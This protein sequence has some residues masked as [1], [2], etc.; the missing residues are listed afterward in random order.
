M[1]FFWKKTQVLTFFDLVS[2]SKFLKLEHF[3]S[4]IEHSIGQFLTCTT[5]IEKIQDF[6]GFIGN[7]FI[8]DGIQKKKWVKNVS[9]NFQ[10][11]LSFS[12]L[13]TVNTLT[14]VFKEMFYKWNISIKPFPAL[15]ALM[16][17]EVFSILF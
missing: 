16:G 2:K 5:Q 13:S 1:P 14:S 8:F 7:P 10:V 6:L 3:I 12:D 9:S 11:F 17:I 15:C 4:T